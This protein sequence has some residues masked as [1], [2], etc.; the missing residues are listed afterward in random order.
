M[1]TR[2]RWK[3]HGAS[4]NREVLFSKTYLLRLSQQLFS[5]WSQRSLLHDEKFF[6][7]QQ[8]LSFDSQRSL[9]HD[10]NSF[11]LQ[12]SLSFCLPATTLE[13]TA[14]AATSTN[15]LKNFFMELPF[16]KKCFLLVFLYINFGILPSIV[17]YLVIIL[18]S[19]RVLT[20]K[21]QYLGEVGFLTLD[22]YTFT[23]PHS[24]LQKQDF[25]NFTLIQ[26]RNIIFL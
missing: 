14:Q 9:L 1:V 16:L 21:H 6:S 10:E 17:R 12:Q 13:A 8:S 4:T 3:H 7:L 15:R 20:N 11:S 18:S 2:E 25:L 23:I 22:C 24:R 19:L 26:N 5:F